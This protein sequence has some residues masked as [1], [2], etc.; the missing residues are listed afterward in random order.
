[1]AKKK[2]IKSNRVSISK[3]KLA[4]TAGEMEEVAVVAATIGMQETVHYAGRLE[5]A[6][7]MAETGA[8][9]LAKGA[10]DIT[11]A[12]DVAGDRS[13]VCLG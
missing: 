4:N 12:A 8:A 5:T 3:R 10:S 13:R 7:D 6:G 2:R 11:Q 1:M 9:L